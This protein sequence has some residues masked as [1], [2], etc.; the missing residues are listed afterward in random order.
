LPAAVD[1]VIDGTDR[2]R[3]YPASTGRS[4][5]S[6]SAK[7]LL[8]PL[9]PRASS[10]ARERRGHWETASI[11]G[12]ANLIGGLALPDRTEPGARRLQRCA[13]SSLLIDRMPGS[14]ALCLRCCTLPS[15]RHISIRPMG[16]DLRLAIRQAT[17]T[18]LATSKARP[19]G[20]YRRPRSQTPQVCSSDTSFRPHLAFEYAIT[21]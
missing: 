10:S 4:K 1:R 15:V 17:A 19:Q 21:L 2:L 7:S 5:T 18:G 11:I 9:R 14:L 13:T 12:A 6:P 3:R 20:P 16:Y 8:W